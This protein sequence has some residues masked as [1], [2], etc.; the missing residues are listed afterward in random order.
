MSVTAV[1]LQRVKRSYLVWLWLGILVAIGAAVGLAWAGTGPVRADRGT[2]EQFLAWHASQP[3]VKTT[4]SG[5]QYQVLE[6]GEGDA[7]PT[8]Q[9]VALFSYQGHLRDGSVF[10]AS[11]RPVP[12]PVA[13]AVPGFSEGLKLMKKK[14]KYRFW[15]KP[16][17]GYGANSPDPS[18]IPNDALL[19]FDVQL[20]DFIPEAAYRQM[21]QMQMG[22]QGGQPGAEPQ[23]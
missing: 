7:H 21:M 13:G 1:P 20:V 15:I 4:A 2:N 6:P 23:R 16:E 12:M 14:S 11:E 22:A 8:D 10:D 3:G 17:L 19:V 18:K 9:D 5:L